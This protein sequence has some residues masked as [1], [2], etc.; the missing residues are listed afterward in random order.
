MNRKYLMTAVLLGAA[1]LAGCKKAETAAGGP[2]Q[3]PPASV[4]AVAAVSKD[5]PVYLDEIGK[6]VAMDVVSIVPQV[7]GKLVKAYVEDGAEVKKGQLLFEIDARP[8]EASLSAA[9]AAV[10]EAKADVSMSSSEYKR[11]QELDK[12]V[13]SQQEYDDKKN[14]ADV[15]LAKLEA[16][17]ADMQMANLNL[18]YTK[19]YSPVDGRAGAR[20]IVPGNIVKENDK[21]NPVMV[22]QR[23]DPIYAEFNVTENDLGTVRKFL[24]SHQNDLG[25]SPEKGLKVEVDVPGDSKQLL[26]ALGSTPSATQPATAPSTRPTSFLGARMGELTFLD[27]AVQDNTG[28]IRVRAT[29]PNADHYFWPGQFVNCRLILT[30]KKDA[31]LIPVEAQQVSQQGIFVYVV[32]DDNTAQIRPITPGQRQGNMLVVESGIAA[33]ERVI[34]TGQMLVMPKGKV[35]VVNATKT[36]VSQAN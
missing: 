15:N 12:S 17:N 28:T 36:A 29:L 7:G 10:A 22:I 20:L 18:E 1:A 24:A 6:V 34:T 2:P 27:N 13:I 19:I 3:M 30:T 11:I 8:F 5:V 21:D 26:A 14:A 4:T 23:L 32:G 31:V 9:K 16:R 25:V 33:G 35:N